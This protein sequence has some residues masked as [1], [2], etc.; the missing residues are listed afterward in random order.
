M[1]CAT[2]FVRDGCL[3]ANTNTRDHKCDFGAE[4]LLLSAP[5]SWSVV[6]SVVLRRVSLTMVSEDRH[7]EDSCLFVGVVPPPAA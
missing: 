4:I 5:N 1:L 7:Y 2:I 6:E 3:R